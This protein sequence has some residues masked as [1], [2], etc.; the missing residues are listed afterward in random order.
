MHF[1]E[2][3]NISINDDSLRIWALHPDT[4]AP[5][6]KIIHLAKCV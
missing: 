4:L 1:D 3:Q 2:F 5:R 6:M